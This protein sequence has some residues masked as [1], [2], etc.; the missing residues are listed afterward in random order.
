MKTNNTF[1]SIEQMNKLT[2]KR[3]LAYKNKLMSYHE[4]SDW[5]DID[6]ISKSSDS[7]KEV[8]ANIKTVLA[9]KE[10]LKKK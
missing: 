6:S 4:T 8:Y 1:L 5:D 7:W 9:T 10:N 3:L 2:T